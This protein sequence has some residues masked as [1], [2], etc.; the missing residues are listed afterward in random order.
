MTAW[1][2]G[3]VERG[4]GENASTA[5]KV[6]KPQTFDG[7]LSKVSRF[8][9]ACKL[10]IRIRLR[11]MPVKEQIQWV[12]SYVQ[13]GSA[14]I[15]KKNVIEEIK[16]REIEFE[17]AGEFL[18]EIRREFRGEDEESVKVVE[19]KKIKQKGRIMEEFVQDFKKT[20]RGSGYKEHPL[21]KEFKQGMNGSIRRK[22]MEA[23]NQLATIEHWFKKAII[24]DKNWRKSRREE[25]R[26][27]GKK[28]NNR[29][30]APRLN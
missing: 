12:L 24:L 22:L 27:K 21:I 5:I 25:K 29:A 15:W 11:D 20:A 9:G 3:A 6:T 16:T 1:I 4:V 19:L 17:T 13:G 26:L 7:T 18:A 10:Y 14:D 28:E 2:E 8:V 23:K 30:P